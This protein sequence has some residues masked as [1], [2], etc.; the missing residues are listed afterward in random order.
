MSIYKKKTVMTVKETVKVTTEENK[1]ENSM[2][3]VAPKSIGK[4]DMMIAFDTTGSMAQYIGAVRQE[5]AEWKCRWRAPGRSRPFS[6]LSTL[7]RESL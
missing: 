5:V 7:S 1:E 3:A 2:D 4:L 6:R